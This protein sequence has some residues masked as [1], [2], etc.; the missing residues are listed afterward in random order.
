V[1]R[2]I[3]FPCRL[4]QQFEVARAILVIEEY[5]LAVVAALDHVMGVTGNGDAGKTRH[6]ICAL[7]PG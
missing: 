7:R 4:A 2:D 6:V 1:D 5:R 3:V